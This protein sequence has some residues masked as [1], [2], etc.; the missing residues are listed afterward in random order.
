MAIETADTSYRENTYHSR[1]MIKVKSGSS[2][3]A[4]TAKGV[5]WAFSGSSMN[6]QSNMALISKLEFGRPRSQQHPP[7]PPVTA[8]VLV[9]AQE[10]GFPGLRPLGL[11]HCF[12]V[13][14]GRHL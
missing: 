14:P 12:P 7:L 8:G 11:S 13:A 6:T 3:E 9:P 2:S 4:V 10:R 5:N 1:F